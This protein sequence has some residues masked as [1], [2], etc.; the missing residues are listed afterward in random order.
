MLAVG[1]IT[2]FFVLLRFD[3]YIKNLYYFMFLEF[4]HEERGSTGGR[5]RVSA[6]RQQ[7]SVSISR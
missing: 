3:F 5:Q 6:V 7:R 4:D 2:Y 1:L